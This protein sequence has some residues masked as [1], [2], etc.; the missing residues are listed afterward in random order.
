M[1]PDPDILGFPSQEQIGHKEAAHCTYYDGDGGN[2]AEVTRQVDERTTNES[3]QHCA[4]DRHHSLVGIE[5]SD[6][7]V[8][9]PQRAMLSTGER[10][11]YRAIDQ[12]A[13]T[14]RAAIDGADVS[15][16]H[17]VCVIGAD[18][19]QGS[20]QTWRETSEGDHQ[21]AH[22]SSQENA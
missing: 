8:L 10:N 12:G 7:L 13:Q 4:D 15:Q 17:A 18:A 5:L 1:A 11:G 21:A 14:L 20:V 3:R 19:S 6:R 22:S 2:R 16:G 9:E